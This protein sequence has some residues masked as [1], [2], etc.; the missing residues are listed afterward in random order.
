MIE[1]PY[2]FSQINANNN[3]LNYTYTDNTGGGHN[4]TANVNI[5]IGN[6]NINQLIS[7]LVIILLTDITTR[8][9]STTISTNNFLIT[10]DS[11]TG[12][13]TYYMIGVA[14]TISISLNFSLN[15]VL[16]LMFGFNQANK[17]FG[18][19]IKLTSNQKIMVNPITSVYLRS[20]TLKFESNYEAVIDKMNNSD[21]ICK[22]PVTTLP[23]SIIYYRNDQCSIV[24][25]NSFASLN[26]YLSD[27]LSTTYT[28]DMQGLNYG[29]YIK[30]DEIMIPNNNGF[31]DKIGSSIPKAP[32]EYLKERDDLLN[33]LLKQKLK[34][35]DEL[36][37][38]NNKDVS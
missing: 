27:N 29:V 24:S 31:K 21:I 1:L 11:M 15:Y 18:T 13:V 34:L 3:V 26:L 36:K 20:E 14:Y 33:D 17:T 7:S 8:I 6:Y 4:Y 5:P 12:L 28:L 23:N 19:S 10:Y 35:E 32:E 2:S 22:I 37:K 9:P 16:G 38:S 30:I 25:N